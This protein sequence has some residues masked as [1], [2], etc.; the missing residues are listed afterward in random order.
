MPTRT[1]RGGL[2]IDDGDLVLPIQPLHQMR[3]H[4]VMNPVGQSSLGM[5][6]NP[7]CVLL[8]VGHQIVVS[9]R[10][11]SGDGD[12]DLVTQLSENRVLRG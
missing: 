7:P 4:P 8:P 5:I 10:Y 2:V 11:A 12:G 9:G 6:R 1:T 3:P